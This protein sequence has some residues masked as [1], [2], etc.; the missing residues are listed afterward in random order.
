MKT[1]S[2]A[3][4]LTAAATIGLVTPSCDSSGGSSSNGP[5][6]I[7]E[8]QA[9]A[10]Y[11]K[12]YCQQLY[13]CGCTGLTYANEATCVS[14]VT[15]EAEEEY[16]APAKATGLTYDGACMGKVIAL[17]DTQ[18]CKTFTELMPLGDDAF[19]PG[20]SPYYG[21]VALGGACTESGEGV[22]N[23]AKGLACD[24][25]KCG[26]ICGKD[27]PQ[28]SEGDTCL[29]EQNDF[30]GDCGEGFT[31]LWSSK[32]SLKIP[33]LGEPCPDGVCGEYA[34]CDMTEPTAPKCAAA[35]AIGQ[36]C[37]QFQCAAGAFCDTTDVAN[38]ICSAR[39]DNGTACKEGEGYKCK[40]GYC[41]E[42][43]KC[44]PEPPFVCD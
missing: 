18:G 40:S 27:F 23:C 34:F 39:F 7:P 19:C 9:A 20:C 43:G 25:G 28:L 2:F 15:T 6:T 22:D 1:L 3:V 26:P 31:C 38:A 16:M 5:S 12:K 30:L 13:A 42:D 11:A 21:T 4:I 8:D 36:P 35:P 14:I 44:A 10:T 29:D 17:Y 33:A 41:G 32:K 37:P 24:E